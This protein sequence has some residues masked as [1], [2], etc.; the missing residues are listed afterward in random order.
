MVGLITM[1]LK[2]RHSAG[3]YKNLVESIVESF[4]NKKEAKAFQ[5]FVLG[6]D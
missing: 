1:D 6:L 5:G 3:F 4:K 2:K